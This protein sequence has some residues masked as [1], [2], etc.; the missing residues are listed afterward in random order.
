MPSTLEDVKRMSQVV[1]VLFKHGLG[2]LIQQAGLSWHLPLINRFR[3]KKKPKDLPKRLREALEELGGAYLKLGQVL[4]MRPDLIPNEYCE[5]FSKLLDRVR[6]ES[7]NTVKKILRAELGK[8]IK[9]IFSHIDEKPLGS[10]SIA[11][12]HK[13]RLKG[14]RSVV[15]KVQR[16]DVRKKFM[17]DID[18]M[19]F[20]AKRISKHIKNKIDPMMVVQEF[21]SYTKKELDFREEAKSIEQIRKA[22]QADKNIEV[23]KVYKSLTTCRLLTMQYLAGVKLTE[24][25]GKLSQTQKDRIIKILIKSTIIQV[26]EKGVF[27]ADLHLGNILILRNR[28]IGLL[29]FGIV[30]SIDRKTIELGIKL[31]NSI[32]SKDTDKIVDAT[33]EYGYATERTDV[34][35]FTQDVNEVIKTENIVRASHQLRRL[36]E[37]S[38]QNYIKLPKNV[39][40]MGKAIITAEATIKTLDPEFDFITEAQH[41]IAKILTKKKTSKKLVSE[42][43]KQTKNMVDTLTVLPEEALETIKTLRRGQIQI[44][45]DDKHLKRI[46]KE[47]DVTGNRISYSLLAASLIMG[48]SLLTKTPPFWGDYSVPSIISYLF[49]LI[50]TSSLLISILK[51][52]NGK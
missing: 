37:I 22:V 39:V 48:G 12:V 6:P 2:S 27:H 52:R 46:K 38:S 8:P 49:A 3:V 10:A 25:V 34:D 36:F 33:L 45:L 11:Q 31:Y 16:P 50:F 4:S 30:G 28:K 17:E 21:E 29:D 23:P 15:V 51:T 1:R 47:M 35:K 40:L 44:E 24:V 13:A 20:I 32:L 14:G 7:F 41:D 9:Q 18:I 26:F 42:F 19:K 5:E 43:L